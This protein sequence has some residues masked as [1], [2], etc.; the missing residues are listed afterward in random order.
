MQNATWTGD[1]N[2]VAYEDGG[3]EL[4]FT[5][6]VKTIRFTTS[7]EDA[8]DDSVDSFAECKYFCTGTF[9]NQPAEIIS[10]VPS[11][12]KG[13]E[14]IQFIDN[15]S[16]QAKPSPL[17]QTFRIENMD[18]GC[19]MTSVELFFAQKSDSLPVRVYLTNTNA[20]KPGSYIIPGTE[21]VKA[22][23]THI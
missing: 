21:I 11:F 18:G 13:S 7:E 5:T 19:F 12:L 20:G 1:I 2:S 14:G 8:N 15:A 16:T 6:G 23:L 10:T 4:N 3:E 17:S 9:P 22:L